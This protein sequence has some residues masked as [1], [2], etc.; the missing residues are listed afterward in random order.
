MPIASD[1]SHA[2]TLPTPIQMPRKEKNSRPQTS[3]IAADSGAPSH[4]AWHDLH[5]DPRKADPQFPNVPAQ[6]LLRAFAITLAGIAACVWLLL[7]FLFWQGSWQLLYHP[8][9][10]V[11]ATPATIHLPFQT[12]S[13]DA[14][15]TGVTQLTGWWIPSNSAI[16]HTAMLLLHG[17]DGDLSDTLPLDA[18]LHAQHQNIFVIDY[19]GYGQSAAGRPS[20]Q[21]SLHDASR[22]IAWLSDTRQ[23]PL[24]GIVLWGTG[25]GATLAAEAASGSTR[26]GG[27]VLDHPIAHPL[28][29]I[30]RDPRSRLVPA[31]LLLRDHYD[32]AAATSHL[33]AP[34]LWLLPPSDEYPP[35]RMRRGAP[36][37][38]IHLRDPFLSDPKAGPA[39]Q[40]WL[41][42]LP[43]FAAPAPR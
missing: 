37:T 11:F 9:R 29:I 12:I 6:W 33:S 17:A 19:R 21:Q 32:L 1:A 36:S 40:R 13:F 14:S 3:P 27:V 10:S 34:S 2:L 16:P 8:S 41:D 23:I 18:W 30:L 35:A 43:A 26:I 38:T 39:L 42:T 22:A 24:T 25:T 20:E 28:N 7:C 5:F 15:E 31:W 4:R